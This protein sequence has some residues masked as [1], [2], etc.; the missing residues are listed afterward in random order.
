M[1]F[2]GMLIFM[3]F[4]PEIVSFVGAAEGTIR[5]V[6]GPSCAQFLTNW[7]FLSRGH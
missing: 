6:V 4:N 3:L 7:H 1:T 2:T 5:D